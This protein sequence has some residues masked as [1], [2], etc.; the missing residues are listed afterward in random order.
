[1]TQG[2]N[3]QS[4]Q[5]PNLNEL[6]KFALILTIKANGRHWAIAS[7]EEIPIGIITGNRVNLYLNKQI[8]EGKYY[9]YVEDFALVLTKDKAGKAS[10]EAMWDK[11][12]NKPAVISRTILRFDYIFTDCQNSNG[13]R[14]IHPETTK[15]IGQNIK[16]YHDKVDPIFEESKAK[17]LA[18]GLEPAV[19]DFLFREKIAKGAK[20]KEIVFLAENVSCMSESGISGM[21]SIPETFKDV[22]YWIIRMFIVILAG[23]NLLK[24][25]DAEMIYGCLSK[26]ETRFAWYVEGLPTYYGANKQKPEFAYAL[27][28]A[29]KYG[30]WQ[31]NYGQKPRKTKEKEGT[32][33]DNPVL[34]NLQKEIKGSTS[35]S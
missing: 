7:I 11:E 3:K 32:L 17:M 29:L 19:L 5:L 2:N 16:E 30:D 28:E 24:K 27:G 18:K 15:K 33:A 21:N 9:F 23:S 34:Q 26:G 10:F 31:E 20:M 25:L 13:I 8:P 1:M 22:D 12:R 14:S 6:E 4:N 35:K